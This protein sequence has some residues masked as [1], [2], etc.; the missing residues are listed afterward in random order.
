MSRDLV[1][2]DLE[3]IKNGA[4]VHTI[5]KAINYLRMLSKDS[6]ILIDKEEREAMYQKHLEQCRQAVNTKDVTKLK[7]SMLRWF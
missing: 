3:K 4:N 7:N 6:W 1:I 5:N 2:A